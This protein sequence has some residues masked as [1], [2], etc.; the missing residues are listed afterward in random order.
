MWHGSLGFAY[1]GPGRSVNEARHT[2]QRLRPSLVSVIINIPSWSE[3][4]ELGP[5]AAHAIS[6]LLVAAILAASGGLEFRVVAGQRGHVP[7][8]E[9]FFGKLGVEC[10]SVIQKTIFFLNNSSIFLRLYFTNYLS[11]DLAAFVGFSMPP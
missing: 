8:R 4:V 7:L 5:G 11:N 3:I 2:S 1:I 10:V 9:Q 6:F